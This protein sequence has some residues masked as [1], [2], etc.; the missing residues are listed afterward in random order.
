MSTIGRVDPEKDERVILPI[1]LNGTYVNALVDPGAQTSAVSTRHV[2]INDID[3]IDSNSTIILANEKE[4]VCNKYAE[5][6][7]IT[8]ADYRQ[9]NTGAVILDMSPQYDVIIGMP[10]LLSLGIVISGLPSNID[11]DKDQGEENILSTPEKP[12][13]TIK[14]L[15]PNIMDILMDLLIQNRALKITD[16]AIFRFNKGYV[17]LNLEQAD[18]SKL[19][20]PTSNYVSR[21]HREQVTA[22]I[23]QWLEDGVI[24]VSYAPTPVNLALLAVDQFNSDGSLRKCRVCL[25][26]SPINKI[27]PTHNFH[28]PRINELLRKIKGAKYYTKIDLTQGYHQLKIYKP[29]RKYFSFQWKGVKYNF[30]GAPFGL[31]MLPSF[32]QQVMMELFA[33]LSDNVQVYI[34]DLVIYAKTEAE[35]TRIV[36]EVLDRLNRH[37]F[38]INEK[39]CQFAVNRIELLGYLI[40]SEGI[41]IDPDKREHLLDWRTPITGKDVNSMCGFVNF[42]TT[43]VPHLAEYIKPFSHLRCHKGKLGD[44]WTKECDDAFK[45]LKQKVMEA[46]VMQFPVDGVPFQVATDA[47]NMAVGGVLYQMIEGKPVGILVIKLKSQDPQQD[48][49]KLK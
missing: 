13:D 25:D 19:K 8:L 6:L 12:S 35:H 2:L 23:K 34:D 40:S 44:L 10:D 36:K 32:F 42:F 31:H 37:K 48:P 18:F 7:S 11:P 38:K 28:L 39:K 15:I 9:I 29:H 17:S 33:D 41:E 47:S 24:E 49:Q 4:V 5:D 30:R 21:K 1:Y 22:Q 43:G 20:C 14:Q 46:P 27:I 16:W 26:M 45:L 3:L